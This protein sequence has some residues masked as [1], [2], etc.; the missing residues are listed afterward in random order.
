[1]MADTIIIGAGISGLA[2]A[3]RLKAAGRD[4]LIL[5][6]R[7]RVG[8]R[9]HGVLL[10]EDGGVDLGPSWV[11]PAF[12]PRIRGLIDALG[13]RHH[14]QYEA[15]EILYDAQGVVQRL[16]HPHRYG[17]ARRIAG[18]PAALAQAMAKQ[19][20]P[21]RLRLGAVVTGLDFSGTPTVQLADGATLTARQ[22]I[23][24]VPP[25]LIASWT[26]RPDLPAT[27]KTGLNRWPTWM[28]AH[29]KFVA[30]YE[31]PF[32]RT[33]GLSGSAL[34]QRGPLMEVV[35]HSDDEVGV[36]A[37]FGFVG[38]PAQTRRQRGEDGLVKDA[39]AQLDRL[40]G[41]QALS[42]AQTYLKDWAADP[43]T[44]GKGDH[45]APNGHPPYGEPALQ[46]LWFDDRLA[47]AGAEADDQHGGLIEG[48]LASAD[49][50]VTRLG[51]FKAAA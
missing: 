19:I 5:E 22:L 36:F 24:A 43:F 2:A 30:R 42:P 44:A 23:V 6:A 50:A 16:A 13:L 38:W 14:A 28:A 37:L 29:A 12:Q 21:A 45:I 27:L 48:A 35:D 47:I 11:W 41:A 46:R 26:V 18:G 3:L 25:R 7:D 17:D 1:M 15:G 8:G 4:F 49:A 51:L 34:S 40:F 39:L 33:A 20:D 32:W 31:Q 10:G 9:A